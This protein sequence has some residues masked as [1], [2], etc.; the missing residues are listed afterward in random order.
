M[1]C[2]DTSGALRGTCVV[3]L[4]QYREVSSSRPLR[5]L[6]PLLWLLIFVGSFLDTV[7]RVVGCA[8]CSVFVI[9]AL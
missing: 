2:P 1:V 8:A 4:V 3:A 9:F 6:T 5:W 7:E